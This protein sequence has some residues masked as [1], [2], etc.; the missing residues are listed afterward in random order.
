MTKS[1]FWEWIHKHFQKLQALDGRHIQ[2]LNEHPGSPGWFHARYP[3]WDV[4]LRGVYKVTTYLLCVIFSPDLFI[5]LLRLTFWRLIWRCLCFLH[6]F[7]VFLLT[8]LSQKN[9]FSFSIFPIQTS[10]ISFCLSICPN[11]SVQL[12]FFFIPEMR[13]ES[14]PLQAPGRPHCICDF[15][16]TLQI[17]LITFHC[18]KSSCP[19]FLPS[20]SFPHLFLPEE[21]NSNP[22]PVL[23]IFHCSIFSQLTKFS[24][25]N[26][27]TDTEFTPSFRLRWPWHMFFFQ[28]S[29]WIM[30][31]LM[32]FSPLSP[33]I[34]LSMW[35]L[36][37]LIPPSIFHQKLPHRTLYGYELFPLLHTYLDYWIQKLNFHL[38]QSV[39]IYLTFR[40]PPAQFKS[41]AVSDTSWQQYSYQC[42]HSRAKN[43]LPQTLTLTH[44]YLIMLKSSELFSKSLQF[45]VWKTFRVDFPLDLFIKVC[46]ILKYMFLHNFSKT[47]DFT[48]SL[49]TKISTQ[50]L[51][52]SLLSY[53]SVFPQIFTHGL[54]LCI[55]IWDGFAK[56]IFLVRCFEPAT[57]SFL[58]TTN[59]PQCFVSAMNHLSSGLYKISVSWKYFLTLFWLCNFVQIFWNFFQI[60]WPT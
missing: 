28:K 1:C 40:L 7:L 26:L 46:L 3:S 34:V 19:S 31:S 41:Q 12:T 23:Y 36:G 15:S 8:E 13:E 24:Y 45:L 42:K 59:F 17:H 39:E 22:I 10:K 9:Q 44:F 6:T 56:M 55:P 47:Q 25:P 33:F 30:I 58:T 50:V 2:T 52:I 48:S 16:F 43:V 53:L 35:T 54:C 51:T 18:Q 38:W 49:T 4:P 37:A 11:T 20:Y 5:S 57:L 21:I 14:G 29:C 32:L 27:T 60:I